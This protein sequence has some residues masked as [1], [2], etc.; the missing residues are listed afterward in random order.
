MNKEV[1]SL[2]AVKK[3]QTRSEEFFP[4]HWYKEM[5][6]KHPVYF[7]EETNTWHVFKYGDVQKVLSDYEFFST[8]GSRTA[9]SVGANNKEGTAPDKVNLVSV[10]PPKH[11][12]KR[13]LFSA[14]FTPRSLKNWEPRIQRIATELVEEIDIEENSTVDIVQALAGPF[15]GMVIAEL[16]GVQIGRAHV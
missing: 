13:S 9:I 7:H 5:F 2:K 12:K 6:N 1:I 15:P 3:F 16:F 8:E 10:D 11:R 4:L 14:A